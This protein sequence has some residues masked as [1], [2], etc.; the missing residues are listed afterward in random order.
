M[1]RSVVVLLHLVEAAGSSSRATSPIFL[2][3]ALPQ[4]AKDTTVKHHIYRYG[5]YSSICGC[6]DQKRAVARKIGLVALEELPAAS[7][8]CR[9]TTTNR[10][11]LA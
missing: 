10:S 7:T 5:L 3:T 8:R 2:A 9:S 1:D 4:A 11:M 6:L